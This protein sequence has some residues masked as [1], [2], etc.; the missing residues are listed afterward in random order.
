M[1]A[2]NRHLGGR[3][4]ASNIVPATGNIAGAP[5]QVGKGDG[6]GLVR[7][8]FGAGQ[9]ERPVVVYG[10]LAVVGRPGGEGPVF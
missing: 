3:D 9:K 1:V 2:H 6:D 8:L 10:H 5:Y 4:H 7:R